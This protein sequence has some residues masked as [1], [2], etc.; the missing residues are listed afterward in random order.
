MGYFA[1]LTP[2]L[3]VLVS[4]ALRLV[5]RRLGENRRRRTD[6][7]VLATSAVAYSASVGIML[8]INGYYAH[9]RLQNP[10]LYQWMSRWLGT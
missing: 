7:L 6:V 2:A 3:W 9:F 4:V 5:E 8:A 10:S 1:D